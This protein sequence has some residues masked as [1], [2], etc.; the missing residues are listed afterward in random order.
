[1]YLL[2]NPKSSKFEVGGRIVAIWETGRFYLVPLITCCN[3]VFPNDASDF[4]ASI[5]PV[6]F[7]QTIKFKPIQN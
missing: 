7:V 5:F 3:N 2:Q 4:H 1:M 6:V